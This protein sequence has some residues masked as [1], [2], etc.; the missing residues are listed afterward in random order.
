MT[1]NKRRKVRRYRGS[2]THGKGSKK[3]RRGSG[4]RGGKGM[5]GTGKRS[6]SKK[7]SIWKEDYFGKRGFI[8]KGYKKIK[9]VNIGFIED[10]LENLSLQNL[11]I[12]EN[13]FFSVDLK[14][15]GFD[16]LLSKGEVKNKYKIKAVY[17]SKNAVEKVKEAGGEVL[18]A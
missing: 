11:A 13:R 12:K 9:A 16:K 7:P 10:N 14:K 18:L 15:M 3:K 17:A 1:V 8:S 5:A 2:Q 4:N 6:D